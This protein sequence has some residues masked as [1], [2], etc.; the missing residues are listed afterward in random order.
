MTKIVF[1]ESPTVLDPEVAQLTIQPCI[2]ELQNI[3]I[4]YERD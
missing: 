1:Y 2:N 3:W 4:P